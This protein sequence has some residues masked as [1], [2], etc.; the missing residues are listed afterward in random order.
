ME[1]LVAQQKI[2]TNIQN[3]LVYAG[4]WSRAAAF[5][6]DVLIVTAV[7]AIWFIVW[8]TALRSLLD[9]SFIFDLVMFLGLLLIYV[10]YFPYQE[11]K[12]GQTLG[13]K[14]LKIKVVKMD[15]TKLTFMN[16]L[17]R[18]LLKI[19]ANIIPFY[20]IVNTIVVASATDKRGLHD[21]VAGTI[22]VKV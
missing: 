1:S 12:T 2:N 11:E 6:V 7:L 9:V 22:V 20:L 15:D 19:L 13:K 8:T 16:A 14:L 4:F 18:W 17:V 21:Q 5:V 3:G 10:G